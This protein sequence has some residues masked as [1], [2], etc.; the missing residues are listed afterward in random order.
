M[1]NLRNHP[2]FLLIAF[3][4]LCFPLGL[5][6]QNLSTK[7][8]P[9]MRKVLSETNRSFLFEFAEV[10]KAE[11]EAKRKAAIQAARAAGLPID[12][13]GYTPDKKFL[14]DFDPVEGPSYIAAENIDAAAT[15]GTDELWS[16]GS[17][18]LSLDGAN[19]YAGS[20]SFLG[21]WEGGE[22][23]TTHQEFNAV[24]GSSVV[25]KETMSYVSDH[26]THV[27]GTMV[28]HGVNSLAKG[29]SF[30][31]RLDCYDWG[32]DDL[33]MA[34]AAS[35]GMLISNHSYGSVSGFDYN[36]SDGYWYWE[37]GASNTEDE[38][39]G[40][41]GYSSYAW[42][43]V[44]V[45]APYYLPVKSGGNDRGDGPNPGDSYY[46]YSGGSWSLTTSPRPKDGGTDGYDCIPTYGNAKN[47]LTVGAVGPITS[48][49]TGP[50]DVSM[51]SFSGWGPT[52]DGRIKPDIVGNGTGVYSSTKASSTSYGFK[53]GTSMSAP[54]VSGSLLLLQQHHEN[55][56]GSG[57][58]MKAAT[59]KGL[60]LHTA[61]EAGS[62][63][64]PD[65]QFGWGLLDAEKAAQVITGSYNLTGGSYID[66]RSLANG[67]TDSLR[68]VTNGQPAS[69]TICWPDPENASYSTSLNNSTPMLVHDLDLY[70]VDSANGTVYETWKLDPANPGNAATKGD[71]DL[72]NVE[73]VDIASIPAGRTLYAII[74]HKGALT[75]LNQDYSVVATGFS[76]YDGKA[77]TA[78]ACL[79]SITS[80]PYEEGFETG[81]GDWSQ[82]LTDDYD[83]T[84]NS[85]PTTSSATGPEFAY[86][87]SEY[88]Y[89][90][91][92]TNYNN[93]AYLE[94]PCMVLS[95]LI[96][97]ELHFAYSMN[98]SSMGTL[99]L[100]VS[101]DYGS[102]WTTAW[103]NN[104]N[105]GPGWNIA[106]VDLSTYKSSNDTIQLRFSMTTGASYQS[107]MAIDD[108]QIRDNAFG[109]VC[110]S[111]ISSYPYTESFETSTIGVNWQNV[112]YD[113]QDWDSETGSTIS[114][115]TGPSV[116]S[117]GT[118]YIYTEASVSGTGY[119]NKLFA[120][121]TPC[122]TINTM[123]DP[124]MRFDYHMYGGDIGQFRVF[125]ST[126]NGSEW[127]S[128]FEA[129]GDQGNTWLS[130]RVDLDSLTSASTV[131]FRFEGHT[132]NGFE[133]DFS[134]DHIR[135]YD[136]ASVGPT[137]NNIV[138]TFPY[139]QGFELSTI[140]LWEQNTTD[141]FDWS[142]NSGP[143]GSTNTGPSAANSGS[144][145]AYTEASSPNYPSKLAII[146]SPCFDVTALNSPRFAY[147]YHMYGAAM[148]TMEVQVSF[149]KGFSWNTAKT[150]TGDQ[151]TAWLNDTI[152]LSTYT[153]LSDTLQVRFYATTG[154]N[155][156]S[157]FSVDDI[158]VFDAAPSGAIT[159]MT[160]VSSYP[161]DQSFETGIGSY[162]QGSSD[163]GDWL[164]NSGTTPSTT[165]GPSAAY[166]GS[167]YMYLEASTFGT[168]QIGPNATANL[169][170]PCL[171][172]SSNSNP[173]LRFAY[174]MYG[175]N[176]GDLY[177]EYSGNNGATWVNLQTISGDQTNSWFTSTLDLSAA[178]ALGSDV[179][180]RFRG[181][182]GSGYA[183]DM[184]I[185]AVSVFDSVSTTYCTSA[186]T[187]IN[188]TKISD[189]NL[190]TVNHST[191]DG[192]CEGYT[193]NTALIADVNP[194]A[195]HSMTVRTTS[196]SGDYD[197]ILKVFIDW[198]QDYDF[199]DAGEEV[200]VSGLHL[201]PQTL[202]F[203]INVPASFTLGST[204]RM[205]LVAREQQSGESLT[206][207]I[208][209]TTP[210]GSY[211]WGE[212]E[213]YTLQSVA[214]A[215]SNDGDGVARIFNNSGVL[216]NQRIVE[217]SHTNVDLRIELEGEGAGTIEGVR[218]DL[219]ATF[220]NL[221]V[222]N[223]S[224]SGPGLSSATAMVS[225][226]QLTLSNA[227]LAAGAVS[228]VSITNLSTGGPGTN[229]DNG[230]YNVDVYTR[231]TSGTLTLIDTLPKLYLT[232]PINN[233]K[234]VDANG[235]PLNDG[236][237]LAVKGNFLHG[238]N[239]ISTSFEGHMEGPSGGVGF[240]SLGVSLTYSEGEEAIVFGDVDQYNGLTEMRPAA[241]QVFKTGQTATLSSPASTMAGI[242]TNPETHESEL[243]QFSNVTKISGTW[244]AGNTLVVSDD[245]G[246]TTMDL[247]ITTA[248]GLGAQPEPGWPVNVTAIVGQKDATSPFDAEYTLIPRKI[249][250]FQT[251]CPSVN[252]S[253]VL[254]GDTVLC[255]GNNPTLQVDSGSGIT[256]Q[257][258]RNGSAIPGATAANYDAT[259]PGTYTV[260]ATRGGCSAFAPQSI[261]IVQ[262][263]NPSISISP[264]GNLTVCDSITSCISATVNNLTTPYVL[265]WYRN[266]LPIVGATSA[267]YCPT[268]AGNYRCDVQK[269]QCIYSSSLLN[270][271]VESS[272]SVSITGPASV[273][274]GN[275]ATLSVSG[276]ASSYEWRDASNVLISTNNSISV[277]P[278]STTTYKLIGF[279]SSATCSTEVTK[280]LTV[281]PSKS[282]TLSDTICSNES[283]T[284]NGTNYTTAGTYTA[285]L[286]AA[287]GCDSV[288]TLNLIVKPTASSAVNASICNGQS[289]NFNGTMLSSAGTYQDTLIAANGCDSVIT[290]T[291]S[292]QSTVTST[293]NASICPGDAYS[294]GG[295]SL[296][297]AGTYRDTLT[298]VGG[299]DSVVTLNL[300]VLSNATAT[301]NA[302]ICSGSTYNFNGQVLASAGTYR[303][304]LE[305]AA[306]NGCDSIV[307]LNLSVDPVENTSL[308]ASVCAGEAYNFNGTML[309]S[310]GTYFD[311]LSTTKGCDS[312]ITLSLAVKPVKSSTPYETICAGQSYN[313]NGTVLSTSG[314]YSDTLTASNGCDSIVHL[315]LAVIPSLIESVA[316]SIC[317]GETYS[318]N[319]QLLSTAGTYKDTLVS[320]GGCDSVVTLSLVVNSFKTTALNET[321]CNGE[322]YSFGGQAIGSSGVYKDTLTAASG[323]DSIVTLNLAIL[324]SKTLSI[325]Q[326][327]CS[328][329]FY[330]F[331]GTSL[332]MA[333]TYKDTLTAAG[334]GCD[335]IVELTLSVDPPVTGSETV[336]ICTGSSYTFNGQVI[337]SAGTYTDTLMASG[338]CDSLA[339]LTLNVVPILST[340]IDRSICSGQT[341]DFNGRSLNTAGH[342]V[343]TLNAAGGCDSVVALNLSVVSSHLSTIDDTI[344]AGDSVLFHGQFYSST[345][346]Y[347]ETLT[348][349]GGCDSTVTLNLFVEANPV[350]DAGA[351][352][353]LCATGAP[354][355]LGAAGT[356]CSWSGPGL[357]GGIL[358]D[359]SLLGPGTYDYVIRCGTGSCANTDT[360][361]VRILASPV[362]TVST[363][364]PSAC[365]N[366]DG[367]AVATVSGQG[368]YTLSWSS[369]DSG[370][371]ANNL[372]AGS[373]TVTVIDTLSGCSVVK[374]FAVDDPNAPTVSTSMSDTLICINSGSLAMTAAPSG[375]A[376]TGTGLSGS[377]F[378]PQAAG[379]GQHTVVYTVD[380][381]GCKASV[382][383]EIAVSAVPAAPVL[384]IDA[385]GK[386]SVSGTSG[387]SYVWLL[388]GQ[389][390]TSTSQ[391]TLNV[392][393]SGNYEVVVFAA[394]GCA[395]DTSN[396]VLYEPTGLQEDLDELVMNVYPNPNSGVFTL[397][398][399]GWKAESARM[400]MMDMTGRLI[401]DQQIALPS[402]KI[403]KQ[404]QLDQAAN[405]MYIL[406]LQGEH[407][408]ARFKV[409]IRR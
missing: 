25:R 146:E 171:D 235:V 311:T 343:D 409:Q 49:Y 404:L 371:V 391:N 8:H 180:I 48:G 60:V 182:T 231:I 170:T 110:S 197:K 152:D 254:I 397:E 380:S 66:E 247:F 303:D 309:S 256:L 297:T 34:T 332:T 149:N 150:Y 30:N 290:L 377:S 264:N 109:G 108:I 164:N 374:T 21:M 335:S 41:Y 56:H 96:A 358:I 319:G 246:T 81:L 9:R 52:D 265:Q 161:F 306:A 47:I 114:T 364:S 239:V 22:P 272:P 363:T 11:S 63:P 143:T 5:L 291:L 38:N 85:G 177:V 14:V 352:A 153:S 122:F 334:T 57:N 368:A 98:G 232:V 406:L 58:F 156:T 220:G 175:A 106:Y 199:L 222:S 142:V 13:H 151:G 193:D 159:C 179:I 65:Y 120:I 287:N 276:S 218:I 351:D 130:N 362:I 387:A 131:K 307:T 259:Q 194:G 141:D 200:Y 201:T 365:G 185:D 133:S 328:G 195:T 169:R 17:L 137:C 223:V 43:Q 270:L 376:W 209:N 168:G 267:S 33:E 91:S 94:S 157:D 76:S 310:A 166:D 6:G 112:S 80:F 79:T 304:T 73:Q 228:E 37:G 117:D 95:S 248:S 16:G 314:T 20:W 4:L 313:F 172:L 97:P 188:W 385:N 102:N 178:K 349:S 330:D 86:R 134:L 111:T 163:D 277:S 145:Y 92:S 136:S 243:K 26:A 395:S 127:K 77:G 3:V 301:V 230:N 59:L 67:A 148:G 403:Q 274:S 28:A 211:N 394:G 7:E 51:S 196:C 104:N 208:T 55:L 45:N 144:Y 132:G 46:E 325:S 324:P 167:Y 99:A 292:I 348:S 32:S 312:I 50:S 70:L 207:A 341:F 273:C 10:R 234:D 23:L 245:G 129:Y 260:Q 138:N 308:T 285:N 187:S 286:T 320:T 154:T 299:C 54:N 61:L 88:I 339:T 160:T 229:P 53:N 82:S 27:G 344:C 326:S 340:A 186:P 18:G 35:N 315:T 113:D 165:T 210:C 40:Q 226:N 74:D 347:S 1:P 316:A 83:L 407:Q 382:S 269:G 190:T 271:S 116:A 296:S 353:V 155:F 405:G 221:N 279:S 268:T 293:L 288:V 147:A 237:S 355:D 15:T 302:S 275:S 346:S 64:G 100:E 219:P 244:G 402:G 84:L 294:F 392:S 280:T 39:F 71:N 128:F 36:S 242:L 12:E 203:N 263:V 236:D 192:V 24:G 224:L 322:T 189:V 212:T 333:G 93:T 372:N 390:I 283:Y 360:V 350:A 389:M 369:G 198:N 318:F 252:A 408:V 139:F 233:I 101:T 298:A 62:N 396:A 42:D 206:D 367:S 386:A 249:S 359:P 181:E 238:D 331:N 258:Y 29:M 31:A 278:T 327:I 90:E 336:S 300:A 183:S 176:M 227:S 215:S 383:V 281:N 103:S 216:L 401:Y 162:V 338:G 78:A 384:S 68:L 282:T 366:S 214:A 140:G 72:D 173:Y 107:D 321:I 174:H 135:I 400:T 44:C 398:I 89:A 261:N 337:S 257:W 105:E 356:G 378:D 284:F 240:W 295:Q 345:G 255:S 329:G 393:D 253:T 357:T 262:P 342:Y 2:L 75:T 225:G 69:L 241:G 202:A 361:K 399:E 373:Y 191:A 158:E 317:S 115:G 370:P 19:M 184:A 381:S 118:D 124:Y 375:G 266:G 125:Y 204:T 250:D 305:N 251:P 213:D 126:D 289:Y 87:G 323:C 388:D 205:R 119:P 379:V 123:T 354:Y 217:H 121:E